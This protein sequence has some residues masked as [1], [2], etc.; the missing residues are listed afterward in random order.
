MLLNTGEEWEPAPEQIQKWVKLYPAIDVNQE[1][2]GM[3][4]W[5]D[6]N[7]TRRK[8]KTGITRFCNT[9]LSRAQDKGGS[10][11]AKAN[12][13]L[14][15]KTRDMSSLD[16]LTQDFDNCPAWREFCLNKYGQYFSNGRRYTA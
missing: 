1:L 2:R 6:A 10:P 11:M 13:G 12:D 4:G 3:T 8:T 7:P 15:T 9:W 5:L 14:I 16:D